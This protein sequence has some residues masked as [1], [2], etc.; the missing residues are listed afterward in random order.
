MSYPEV[1]LG[2]KGAWVHGV[3]PYTFCETDADCEAIDGNLRCVDEEKAE[4][5]KEFSTRQRFTRTSPTHC[6]ARVGM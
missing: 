6:A 2:L 5:F 4:L 1:T 3:M